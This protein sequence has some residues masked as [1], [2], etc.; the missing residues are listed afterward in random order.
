MVEFIDVITVQ[1]VF[2]KYSRQHCSVTGQY[3]LEPLTK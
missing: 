1:N 3:D 2:V